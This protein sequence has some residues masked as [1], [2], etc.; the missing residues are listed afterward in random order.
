MLLYK[1]NN[2]CFICYSILMSHSLNRTF[3]ISPHENTFNRDSQ[4]VENIK[5]L[6][7]S[8]IYNLFTHISYHFDYFNILNIYYSM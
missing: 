8:L 4:V 7:V 3:H 5:I 1:T 6:Y 2:E